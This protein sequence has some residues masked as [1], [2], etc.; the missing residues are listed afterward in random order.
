MDSN[1]NLTYDKFKDDD[2]FSIGREQASSNN[3][4]NDSTDYGNSVLS[5]AV[6]IIYD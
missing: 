4:D 1:V 5:G 3:D 6:M 2:E